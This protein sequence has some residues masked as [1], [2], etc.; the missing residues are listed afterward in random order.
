MYTLFLRKKQMSKMYWG[1]SVVV[2]LYLLYK[3]SYAEGLAKLQAAPGNIEFF[4]S[5]GF[6]IIGMYLS[7]FGEVFGP[8]LMLH[9]KTSFYGAMLIAVNFSVATYAIY[10]GG[11][12]NVMLFVFLALG[13]VVAWLMRPGFLR[14]TPEITTVSV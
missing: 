8:I 4:N 11:Q 10:S 1:I 6:G 9:W 12:S 7:G 5:L 14:K 13:L 3:V 2:A